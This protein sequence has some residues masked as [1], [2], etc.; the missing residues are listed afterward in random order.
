MRQ[1]KDDHNEN[2]AWLRSLAPSRASGQAEGGWCKGI[3]SFDEKTRRESLRKHY[4]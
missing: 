2:M 1:P 4:V 3:G